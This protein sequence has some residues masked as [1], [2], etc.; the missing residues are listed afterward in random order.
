[1]SPNENHDTPPGKSSVCFRDWPYW[2]PTP[3][4]LLN[5]IGKNIK[6]KIKTN[7]CVTCFTSSG[8]YKE[9]TCKQSFYH[10]DLVREIREPTMPK[11]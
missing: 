8:L 4:V 11:H 10:L 2:G 6:I 9:N 5:F 1:M 3:S 7:L